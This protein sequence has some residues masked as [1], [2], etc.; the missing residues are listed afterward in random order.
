M[1]FA[2]IFVFAW[3]FAEE[4]L[5]EVL[6]RV[7][8]LGLTH[9]CYATVYHAGYFMH[10]HSPRRKVRLLEDGVAYFHPK[11]ERFAGDALRPRVA[12]MCRDV[13]WLER[14]CRGAERRGL[15]VTAWTICLHN[16]RLGLERPDCTV[17]NAFG[18]G[19]PH[20]LS[21]A[22]PAARAYVR[23]LVEDLATSYPIETVLLEAPNYRGQRHAHHHE[24]C[25]VHLRPL[26]QSLIDLSFGPHEMAG[27][28]ANG[29]AAQ[30]LRRRVCEHLQRCFAEAPLVPT[31]LPASR[32]EFALLAP[33]LDAYEHHLRGVEH[34]LLVDL[35]GI[36]RTAGVRI[37]CAGRDPVLDG[38]LEGAYG[39]TP[40]S[41]ER[42][43]RTARAQI[44]PEQE[45][46]MAIRVG[47]NG[48]G[49]SSPILSERATAEVVSASEA[50]GADGIDFYNYSESPR[51][52]LEW[53]KPALAAVRRPQGAT[54]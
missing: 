48:P 9:V 5:D 51:R 25:G 13:D 30:R 34:S 3:D 38:I 26:E 37:E 54:A 50:G 1:R 18:D 20:A 41:V 11:A 2:G 42:I 44:R 47:F 21:P 27:A 53:I 40:E 22:H 36:A 7:A 39:E 28:E 31:D 17:E 15:K 14:V 24:R 35:A 32:D 46:V 10:P 49:M 4:G 12:E 6:D 29:I 8:A 23:G 45:L 33:E 19:Y 16:T 52:S 43:T